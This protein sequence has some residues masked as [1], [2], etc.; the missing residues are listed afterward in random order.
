MTTEQKNMQQLLDQT[1]ARFR[2]EH[3]LVSS[4]MLR[5]EALTAQSY[6]AVSATLTQYEWVIL[7]AG[8]SFVDTLAKQ[9][10]RAEQM[11]Q[12]KQEEKTND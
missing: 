10:E 6:L 12:A 8:L 9:K 1:M 5:L 7:N 4:L 11:E 3:H 2:R